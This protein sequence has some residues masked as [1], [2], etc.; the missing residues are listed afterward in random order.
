MHLDPLG[1]VTI[2]L[3]KTRVTGVQSR[4]S[5][6]YSKSIASA[7]RENPFSLFDTILCLTART[8]GLLRTGR[9][10]GS[11]PWFNPPIRCG[12]VGLYLTPSCGCDMIIWLHSAMLHFI[13][14]HM[15]HSTDFWIASNRPTPW[16]NPTSVTMVVEAWAFQKGGFCPNSK[17]S[18][19][20]QVLL[21]TS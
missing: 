17:R 14:F 3:G 7:I 5:S 12:R 13:W 8:F 19:A 18:V 4:E 6:R 2:L 1:K 16:F 9:L 20:W 10:H 21:T 11:T 15:S